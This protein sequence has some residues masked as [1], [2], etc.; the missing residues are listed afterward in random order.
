M[1]TKYIKNNPLSGKKPEERQAAENLD[2]RSM[3][4]R[5][6]I[7]GD[8]LYESINKYNQA[9]C[10][11]VIKGTTDAYIVLGRDRTG[12]LLEGRGMQGEA[13]ASSI[14]VVVGRYSGMVPETNGFN[15]DV[16][17]NPSFKK[18]AARIYISQKT[19]LDESFGIAKGKVGNAVNRSGLA[20]KADGIRLLAREGIKLVTRVDEL[21][22]KGIKPTNYGIDLIALNDD[23]D[24]QPIPKGSNLVNAF[25]ALVKHV[26]DLNKVVTGF[27]TYQMQMNEAIA[28]HQ[29]QSPFDGALTNQ[30]ISLQLTKGPYIMK[31]LQ[32]KIDTSLETNRKEL[33]EFKRI[34][35]VDDGPVYINSKHNNTN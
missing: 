25:N 5:L 32:G 23:T 22:S 4:R 27:L 8:V 20:M 35:L 17:L 10:E 33:Q 3:S 26:S 12:N 16:P 34:F 21:N 24:L 14:D 13:R 7:A 6:G 9:P 30:S 19:D 31:E 29:H 11:K 28:E 15:E 1:T 2:P 18:D